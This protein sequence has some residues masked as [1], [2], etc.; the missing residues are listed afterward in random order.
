MP[1]DPEVEEL[2]LTLQQ[3]A[4]LL[5]SNGNVGWAGK[6]DRCREIIGNSDFYGVSR[7]LS[8]YGGMGSLNDIV[9][10]RDGVM[11]IDKNERFAAL[12]EKAWLIAERLR[13]EV[14]RRAIRKC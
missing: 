8:L 2:A 3:M 6:L 7:L 12:K 10:E 4:S 11:L 9:L 5:R 14:D 1:H 13:R